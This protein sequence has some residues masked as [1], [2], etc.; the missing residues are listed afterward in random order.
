MCLNDHKKIVISQNTGILS[1]PRNPDSV[2]EIT[3]TH[4]PHVMSSVSGTMMYSGSATRKAT[5]SGTA[6][7]R[8]I[9][10]ATSDKAL[11]IFYNTA[12]FQTHKYLVRSVQ[13]TYVQDS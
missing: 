10:M 8:S 13:R 6:R 9:S 4:V 12:E 11:A 7:A 3:S 5:E 2:Y 1:A